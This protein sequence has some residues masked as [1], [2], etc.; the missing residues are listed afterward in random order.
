MKYNPVICEDTIQY[1]AEKEDVIYMQSGVPYRYFNISGC[2]ILGDQNN[3]DNSLIRDVDVF[4][5]EILEEYTLAFIS[6]LIKCF[7]DKK[8]ISLDCLTEKLKKTSE[9]LYVEDIQHYKELIN[10]N[11][12]F[13]YSDIPQR[14]QRDVGVKCTVSYSSIQ[15]LQSLCWARKKVSLGEENAD[16]II[17]LIE[18]SG[19]NAGMGDI[20]ISAQQ[21]IRLA[22]QRGWYPVVYLTE[23]NQYVS[24]Y[25]ENMWDYYFEQPAGISA[26]EALNSKCVIRG[27]ENCFGVLPWVG[28]PL[29][30]MKDAL[31][32]KILLKQNVKNTFYKS[33]PEKMLKSERV[34]GVIARGSDLAKCSHIKI[35]IS[36][37]IEEV[38]ETFEEKY[39]YIFLATED[40]DYQDRFQKEFGDKLLYIE[41]KRIHHDYEKEEY[42]YVADLLEVDEERR[43]EWGWK[44]LLITY[45][46]SQCGEL[47]YSIPCGALR[48][49]EIWREKPFAS[50]RCTFRSVS[51][52]EMKKEAN[53][54]HIYE[55]E[56]FLQSAPLVVIYGLGDVAQMIYPIID[57]YRH[58]VIACDKRATMEDCEFHGIKVISPKMLPEVSEE[59]KILITSPRCGDEIRRELEKMGME[60]SRI[61]QLDY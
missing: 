32:E 2:D 18:F 8:I 37:M 34:L 28:N 45:C 59:A 30:N 12:M 35:D 46:L 22:R 33:M 60:S 26:E 5:I 50:I 15:L 16:K 43:T 52:L 1:Q 58:K 24:H 48:L 57:K 38:R 44:Y 19:S 14:K 9:V 17:L 3:L 13:V 61:I 23:E 20:V 29:C 53:L 6:Y 27:K 11:S 51:A 25:G 40:S 41:Q 10:G 42:K 21:Y 7:P 56:Y 47:L 36:N 4:I 49:A 31:K 39:D 54:I 55:C